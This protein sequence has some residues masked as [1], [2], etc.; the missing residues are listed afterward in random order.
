MQL[1]SA[2]HCH[3]DKFNLFIS[4]SDAA[5]LLQACQNISFSRKKQYKGNYSPNVN[6]LE[7]FPKQNIKLSINYVL[8]HGNC[9]VYIVISWK[10]R[11]VRR[12]RTMP[13]RGQWMLYRGICIIL[14]RVTHAN[15]HATTTSLPAEAAFR[16]AE[17]LHRQFLLFIELQFS[18]IGDTLQRNISMYNSISTGS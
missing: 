16:F 17:H 10:R 4:F 3:V 9:S 13:V 18:T 8:V 2:S 15:A 5:H 7:M 12:S 14:R 1:D 6:R 11:V